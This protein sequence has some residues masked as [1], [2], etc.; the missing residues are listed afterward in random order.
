MSK[1]PLKC[2]SH[3]GFD[4]KWILTIPLSA[5]TQKISAKSANTRLNVTEQIFRL[6]FLGGGGS[7]VRDYSQI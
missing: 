2:Q 4:Q 7:F 6:I 3:V 1:Y 5:M